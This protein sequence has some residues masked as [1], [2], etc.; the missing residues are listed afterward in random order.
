MKSTRSVDESLTNP[1]IYTIASPGGRESCEF[2]TALRA[3]HRPTLRPTR[4][5]PFRRTSRTSSTA[6]SAE[7]RWGAGWPGGPGWPRPPEAA[8]R[9]GRKGPLVA[10]R[11]ADDGDHRPCRRCGSDGLPHP[12]GRWTGPGQ[13]GHPAAHQRNR[14]GSV[15]PVDSE[16]DLVVARCRAQHT[17]HQAQRHPQC[18]GI[19]TR[20]LRREPQHRQ[21]RRGE[22]DPLSDLRQGQ[23]QSLRLGSEHPGVRGPRLSALADAGTAAFRYPR[24]QPRLPRRRLHQLPGSAPGR[25]GRPRR[26]LRRAEGA[27]RL[28]QSAQPCGRPDRYTPAEGDRLARIPAGEGCGRQPFGHGDEGIRHLRREGPGLGP[29]PLGRQRRT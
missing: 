11:A 21:L 8:A 2:R 22:A 27:L 4:R 6:T 20:P 9:R 5:P 26:W 17:P 16:H 23:E 13:R 24:H 15:H 28:W 19:G 14:A 1:S 29:P 18:G 7:R 12:P 10:V 25:N 3:S